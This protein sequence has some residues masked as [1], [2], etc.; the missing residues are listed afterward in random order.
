MGEGGASV[1]IGFIVVTILCDV[2]CELWWKYL[3]DVDRVNA[4]IVKV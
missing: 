4:E 3:F 2:K 1:R